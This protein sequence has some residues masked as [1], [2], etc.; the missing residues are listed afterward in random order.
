[1]ASLRIS[2]LPHVQEVTLEDYLLIN[3]GNTITSIIAAEDYAKNIITIIENEG[4]FP[5]GDIDGGNIVPIVYEIIDGGGVGTDGAPIGVVLNG[6][7]PLNAG[8]GPSADGGL[9]TA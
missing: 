3:S 9:V 5:E 1:M 2:D 8:Y 7:T 6:G 4:L